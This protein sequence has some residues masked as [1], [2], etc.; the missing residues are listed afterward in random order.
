MDAE[1]AAHPQGNLVGVVLEDLLL[2]KSLL[3]LQGDHHLL[4]F[5][6]P[7]LA[8]LVFEEEHV[9]ELR[10]EGGGSLRSAALPQVHVG[11]LDDAKRIQAV[12]LEETLVLD[13]V[14]ASTR[15]LGMPRKVT[16]RRFSRA[17][18]DRLVMSCGSNWYWPRKVLSA[19]EMICEILLP[20]NRITPGSWSKYE[21]G[22]GKISSNWR[23]SE[24]TR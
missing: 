16:K 19:R 20:T 9:R 14:T 2:G 24:T 13:G 5:A 1:S 23:G 22:P 6:A 4:Q 15:I 17:G 18:P 21:S 12:V 10:A 3:D 8:L 11:G 7:G